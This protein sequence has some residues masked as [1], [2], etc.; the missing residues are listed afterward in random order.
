MDNNLKQLNCPVC[1]NSMGIRILSKEHVNSI[2]KTVKKSK[3]Y[4]YYCEKCGDG[5]SGF[6]TTESDELSIKK[7]GK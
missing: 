7:F 1:G 4:Q 6:T 3:Y 2:S 5:E